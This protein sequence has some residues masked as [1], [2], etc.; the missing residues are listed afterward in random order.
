MINRAAIILKYKKPAVEWV[1]EADP[2]VTDPGISIESANKDGTVYLIRT[3]DAESQEHID[4]W[5]KLNYE[6]LF[7]SEL[8]SWCTDDALWP[9]QRDLKLFKEW[10]DVEYFTLLHDTVSEQIEDDEPYPDAKVH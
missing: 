6:A 3:E 9:K 2:V 8:D 10:F 1:N 5:V 7:E 4:K